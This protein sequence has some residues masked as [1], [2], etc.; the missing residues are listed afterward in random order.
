[1]MFNGPETRDAFSVAVGRLTLQVKVAEP[2][3]L[4]V[5]NLIAGYETT[6]MLHESQAGY[7]Y[8]GE[9]EAVPPD[10]SGFD[11]TLDATL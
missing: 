3:G 5:P 9:P 6:V 8:F 2:N 7:Y 4:F 11:L 1:M 10:A